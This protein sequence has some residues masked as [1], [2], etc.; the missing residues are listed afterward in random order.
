MILRNCKRQMTGLGMAWMDYKKAFDMVPYSWLK[1]CMM[2]G[3]AENMQKVLSNSMKKWK[4]DLTSGWKKFGTARIRRSTFHI[5][6]RQ[7]ISIKFCVSTDT[8]VVSLV[9]T[10]LKAEYQLRDLWG[11]VNHLLLLD[12]LKLYG[13]NEKQISQHSMNI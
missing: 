5:W 9:L 1:K 3:V 2:F 13:Q 12:D 10:E 11:K 8:H 4:T 6:G 7:F